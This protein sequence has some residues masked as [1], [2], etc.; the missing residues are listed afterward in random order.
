MNCLEIPTIYFLLISAKNLVEP[1]TSTKA[2]NIEKNHVLFVEIKKLLAFAT[3][4]TGP[5][6]QA[7]DDRLF[8]IFGQSW[9]FDPNM[10]V[11]RAVIVSYI[12]NIA[13]LADYFV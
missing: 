4:S 10:N 9:K 7:N 1:S 3:L 8:M 2:P 11:L 12:R 6:C 13:L 5:D